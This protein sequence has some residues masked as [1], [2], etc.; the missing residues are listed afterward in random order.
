MP[1]YNKLVRDLIPDIIDKEGKKYQT[2]ILSDM[3][4]QHELIK[5]LQEEVTE[6]TEQPNLEELADI[7]E[8]IQALTES[9]GSGMTTVETIKEQKAQDRGGFKKRIFLEWVD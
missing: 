8:V 9:L 3:E 2:R 4:Y 1:K 5:K 6:F 7:L